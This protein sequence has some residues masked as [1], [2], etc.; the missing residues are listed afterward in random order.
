MSGAILEVRDLCKYFPMG[1]SG[2]RG[3]GQEWLKAVDG[4][5]FDLHPG[6]TL[7]LVGESGCG[8]STCARTI[9]GLYPPTAGTIRFNGNDL[10]SLS[11][12]G[13]APYRRKIQMIFQDP[14]ASLDPRQTVGSILTEPMAIH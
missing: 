2:W 10:G 14:F 3:A 8:K 7:G 12:R 4:V 1:K 6:Q 9:V 11:P 13:W 5:S